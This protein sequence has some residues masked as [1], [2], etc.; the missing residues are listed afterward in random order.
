MSTTRKYYILSAV[1]FT[2]G[3]VLAVA[4]QQA[5]AVAIFFTLTLMMLW[6]QSRVDRVVEERHPSDH[7]EAQD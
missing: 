4:K 2:V 6:I 3:A 7:P 1:I 5:V